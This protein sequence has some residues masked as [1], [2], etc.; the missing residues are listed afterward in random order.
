VDKHAVLKQFEKL[1]GKVSL[2]TGEI[3]LYLLLLANCRDTGDGEIEYITI[4]DALGDNRYMTGELPQIC[5][6]LE[7][8]G[9][10]EVL[11]TS[12]EEIIADNSILTYRIPPFVRET[13]R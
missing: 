13:V 7:E 10:I 4:K 3:R 9:V 6:H 8:H 11:S 2:N 12:L 5:R 1:A